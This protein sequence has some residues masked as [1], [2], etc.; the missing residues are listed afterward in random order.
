[1]QFP[2]LTTK[3]I[4]FA[5]PGGNVYYSGFKRNFWLEFSCPSPRKAFSPSPTPPSPPRP[6]FLHPGTN[7]S[8]QTV[9]VGRTTHIDYMVNNLMEHQVG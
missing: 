7:G 1:M 9:T 3:Y 8:V 4:C 2:H 5:G 6:V